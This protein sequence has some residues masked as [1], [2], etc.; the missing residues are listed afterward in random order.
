MKK[1]SI[2]YFNNFE[3]DKTSLEAK[4]HY[5]FDN[6]VFFEEVINFNSK[7][8]SLINN[9]DYCILDNILFNIHIA[10]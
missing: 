7:N 6:D 10:L 2:F 9:I 1:F 3:F 8:F 5:S 4:F